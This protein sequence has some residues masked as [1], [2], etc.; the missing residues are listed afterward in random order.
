[1]APTDLGPT[2]KAGQTLG[3]GQEL[4]SPDGSGYKMTV[5]SGNLILRDSSGNTIFESGTDNS[6][7]TLVAT[8]DGNKL[9]LKNGDK[10]VWSRDFA[11]TSG[12]G[13]K[14]DGF[15]LTS[16]GIVVG[17]DGVQQVGSIFPNTSGHWFVV[18]LIP[19]P[20]S[21]EDKLWPDALK[22]VVAMAQYNLQDIVDSIGAQADRPPSLSDMSQQLGGTAINGWSDML[23][24]YKNDKSVLERIS[25]ALQNGDGNV[26]DISSD[27]AAKLADTRYRVSMDISQLHDTLFSPAWHAHH[28][29]VQAL[30]NYNRNAKNELYDTRDMSQADVDKLKTDIDDGR[31]KLIA[32]E[33]TTAALANDFTKDG[34][35]GPDIVKYLGDQIIS[36]VTS[37]SNEAKAMHDGMVDA[38]K[39]IDGNAPT[40]KPKH[41]PDPGDGEKPPPGDGQK[42]PPG[43]GQK[44]PPGDGTPPPGTSKIGGHVDFPKLFG[45]MLGT[46]T[47]TDGSTTGT[48]KN[49]STGDPVLDA[50][51]AAIDKIKNSGADA[52]SSGGGGLGGLLPL[53]MIGGMVL[54]PVI[55]AFAPTVLKQLQPKD[56][57]DGKDAQGNPADPN[58]PDPNAA[59]AQPG[60]VPATVTAPNAGTPPPTAAPAA[61]DPTAPVDMKFDGTT[62]KVPAVVADAVSR[63]A[64][65]PNGSDASAAYRGT[66][67]DE[68]TWVHI[69]PSQL[70]TGDVMRWDHHSALIVVDQAG[71][72]MVVDGHPVSLDTSNPPDGHGTYGQFHGYFH[73]TGLDPKP[74]GTTV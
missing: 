15:G 47:G 5:E 26:G 18:D 13:S 65:N 39:F 69:D 56:G 63:E 46:D 29:A 25:S 33:G 67:A 4:T 30:G 64:N 57:K 35:Y 6:Q 10:T 45:D 48:G 59:P 61:P 71:P 41:K 49:G 14:A 19:S 1:M 24:M 22:F 50:V 44:P 62:Q 42:P 8:V 27:V 11:D 52:S 70:R 16:N 54:A 31:K 55:S 68:R 32:A 51:N 38:K 2:L 60:V 23:D 20:G 3:E 58:A 74:A 43:D 72:Q 12:P 9:V 17:Y 37:V 40:Y 21:P 34:K 7:G 53:L 28:D 36:T 66:V 73:P